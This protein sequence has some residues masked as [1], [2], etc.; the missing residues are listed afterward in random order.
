V[1][2]RVPVYYDFAS[3]LCYVAHRV[4]ER[5]G[6]EL[7]G[8][9][10]ELAWTPVDLTRMSGWRRGDAIDGVRRENAL[11]VA[12]ELEVPLRMPERWMDSRAAAAV[13]LGLRGTQ[14]AAAWREAVFARVY[15]E[16]RPLDGPGE[17]EHLAGRAAL[18][19]RELASPR[20]LERIEVETLLAIEAQVTGVPTF[21]LGEWPLGGIQTPD[22]MRSL[23]E[24]YVRKRRGLR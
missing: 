24:R 13:A 19:L 17:L 15:R 9:G 7:V 21:M 16:G 18:D 6:E 11:R 12:K 8:L 5:M 20:A 10:I 22:T 2:L 14:A 4:M 3:S 1:E 23:F